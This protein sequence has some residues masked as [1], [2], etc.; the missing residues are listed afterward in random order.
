MRLQNQ[1]KVA[2]NRAAGEGSG[3]MAY[4]NEQQSPKDQEQAMAKEAA[5]KQKRELMMLQREK[6]RISTAAVTHGDLKNQEGQVARSSLILNGQGSTK[7]L[8]EKQKDLIEQMGDRMY[9]NSLIKGH[10]ELKASRYFHGI[11]T[12]MSRPL[13]K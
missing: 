8:Q 11:V 9:S 12:F 13:G 10:E 1:V 7:I 6:N 4:T 5:K 3:S 2:G